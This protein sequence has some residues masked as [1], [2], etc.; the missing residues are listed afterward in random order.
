MFKISPLI[1]VCL[2]FMG[3]Q[4]AGPGPKN[5]QAQ[6]D[7]AALIAS[8]SAGIDSVLAG[9][10]AP[11]PSGGT[12]PAARSGGTPPRWVTAPESVYD[13]KTYISAVGY[14]DNRDL[15]ERRALAALTAI[16][17]QSIQSEVRSATVYSEAVIN[18]AITSATENNDL[19][20]LI[21]TSVDMDSLVGAEIKDLWFDG[22]GAYYAAAVME[23][24]KT[25]ALY[26]DLINTNIRLINDLTAIPEGEK[27]T[28]EGLRKLQLAAIIADANTTFLNVLRVVGDGS[29]GNIPGNLK[30][31]ND[32]RLEMADI[33][34]NIPIGILVENDPRDRIRGAFSAVITQAG[35]RSGGVNSPYLLKAQVNM[36]PVDLPN[37]PN[38]FVR[39]VVDANLEDARTGNVLLPF[40]VD[41][42]E[43]HLS[44]PEAENRAIRAAEA[45]IRE[46]YGQV[47]DAYISRLSSSGK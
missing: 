37:N 5:N 13:R 11:A 9:S 28:L 2:F 42:R 45:E 7:V 30:T 24:A 18:G 47:L 10:R 19:V 1:L 32:Y 36:I 3:C 12:A 8:A 46:T 26:K 29:A 23:R 33:T 20:N 40:M 43:G 21:K 34:K 22:T 44:I 39:Y 35:F 17:G 4:S 6:D 38:K 27:Y 41:G 14:G 16:F 15:A 31:G 25:A